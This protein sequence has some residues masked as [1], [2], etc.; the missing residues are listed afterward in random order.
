LACG[1]RSCRSTDLAGVEQ[2]LAATPNAAADFE[3]PTNP[4]SK[5]AD[6]GLDLRPGAGGMGA[7][8]AA[9]QHFSPDLNQQVKYDHDCNLHS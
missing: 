6:L 1:I 3:S 5:I 2:V 8:H 4:V 9:E 7:L